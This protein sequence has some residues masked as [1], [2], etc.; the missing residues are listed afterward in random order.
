APAAMAPL[1]NV[2]EQAK[3]SHQLFHQNA[4]A[5]VRQFNLKHDQARAIVA[6]CPECHQLALPAIG[7]GA[8]PRGLSNCEVW[9]M[10]VT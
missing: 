2:F 3:I 9:Q 6:A 4:P 10:D 8:N 5:L 1:P 7:T